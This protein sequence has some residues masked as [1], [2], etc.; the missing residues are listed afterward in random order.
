[1]ARSSQFSELAWESLYRFPLKQS[2]SAHS[3]RLSKSPCMK[4]V[5]KEFDKR[6]LLTAGW[7]TSQAD[8]RFDCLR[9]EAAIIV[10]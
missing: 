4:R 8:Q 5:R 10:I 9:P 1:M 6:R 3:E 7:P 2:F